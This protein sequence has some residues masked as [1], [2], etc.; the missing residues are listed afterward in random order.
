MKQTDFIPEMGEIPEKKSSS[1]QA[2]IHR[3]LT[4]VDL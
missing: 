4:V 2:R 3:S 1:I